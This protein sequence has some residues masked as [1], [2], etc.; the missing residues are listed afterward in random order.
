MYY[1]QN[2]TFP[3]LSLPPLL[4]TLLSLLSSLPFLDMTEVVPLVPL[5]GSAQ[6]PST[7]V[8]PSTRPRSA[9]TGST[10]EPASGPPLALV[11][12]R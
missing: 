2:K 6:L 10:P 3:P 1:K 11:E 8:D 7:P 4:L 12:P 5:I 9:E